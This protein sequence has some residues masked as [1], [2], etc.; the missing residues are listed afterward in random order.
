MARRVASNDRQSLEF[1]QRSPLGEGYTKILLIEG[2]EGRYRPT[3][4]G[5]DYIFPRGSFAY[6]F[7]RLDVQIANCNSPHVHNVSL[8]G[9]RS[10]GLP[11]HQ[12]AI[13]TRGHWRRRCLRCNRRWPYGPKVSGEWEGGY[14][15]VWNSIF[16]ASVTRFD[17]SRTSSNTRFPLSS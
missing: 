13:R 12:S 2:S 8:T 5:D 16:F 14:P 17:A 9:W 15:V 7:P 10:N 3:S 6:P 11:C 1:R 4:V